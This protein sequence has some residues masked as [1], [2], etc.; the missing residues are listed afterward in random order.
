MQKRKIKE[1]VKV[2]VMSALSIAILGAGLVATNQL[3]FANAAGRT[4]EMP[5]MEGMNVTFVGT[6][7]GT[8]GTVLA[9]NTASSGEDAHVP[10]YAYDYEKE[11]VYEEQEDYS[12][13]APTTTT[14]SRSL[15]VNEDVAP[16]SSGP[17]GAGTICV[18]QAAHILADLIYERFGECINGA[19]I[20]AT[21]TDTMIFRGSSGVWNVG[22]MANGETPYTA[23]MCADTGYVVFIKDIRGFIKPGVM[24][25]TPRTL[26]NFGEP[27]D[28]YGIDMELRELDGYFQN[29]VIIPR[30]DAFIRPAEIDLDE[31]IRML[32][33]MEFHM[34]P[35]GWRFEFRQF[36][37]DF[38]E[39][40]S[41]T[42]GL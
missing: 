34:P 19:T 25:S 22:V 28:L 39:P 4:L 31:L 10:D 16:L 21:F 8:S 42:R 41:S 24:I 7:M 40:Q 17:R 37:I 11:Y 3:V 23:I 32:E 2:V 14:T 30:E 5:P 33:G 29:R 15:T 9:A 38:G 13:P 18:T 36:E 35:D 27:I 26:H 1:G 12:P 6:P 20:H